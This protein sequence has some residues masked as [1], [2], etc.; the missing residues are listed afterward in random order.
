MAEGECKNSV[1]R[2]T[3]GLSALVLGKSY[4]DDAGCLLDNKR[5]ADRRDATGDV[6]VSG[7]DTTG[8]EG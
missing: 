8:H 3:Q 2:D 4:C 5:I 6:K 7:V 1:E